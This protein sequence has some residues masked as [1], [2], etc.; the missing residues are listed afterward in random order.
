MSG[1]VSCVFTPRTPD[2]AARLL[3]GD[4]DRPDEAP[5]WPLGSST[6]AG[7][8]LVERLLN[9]ARCDMLKWSAA[10]RQAERTPADRG[11]YTDTLDAFRLSCGSKAPDMTHAPTGR[12]ASLLSC[13]QP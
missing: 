13:W 8:P 4:D 12:P 3:Y 7:E 11:L 9:G 1:V 2:L 6:G 10:S 5:Y